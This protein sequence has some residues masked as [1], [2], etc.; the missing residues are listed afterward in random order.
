MENARKLTLEAFTERT[1]HPFTATKEELELIGARYLSSIP[2]KVKER[3]FSIEYMALID[4]SGKIY[5]WKRRFP[6]EEDFTI[7]LEGQANKRY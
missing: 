6:E 3:D 1:G 2:L 4:E 5:L 7:H